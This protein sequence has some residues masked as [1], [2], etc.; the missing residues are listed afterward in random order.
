MNRASPVFMILGLV[1]GISIIIAGSNAEINGDK[2]YCADSNGNEIIGKECV[3]RDQFPNRETAI[4]L[5]V[6]MG[7][8]IIFI[9]HSFGRIID[10]NT[11]MREAM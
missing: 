2:T 1:I 7:I 5:S 11:S 10:M 8:L 9:F 3:V 6:M 4:I